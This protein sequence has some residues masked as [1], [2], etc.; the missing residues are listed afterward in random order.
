MQ[1][2]HEAIVSNEEPMNVVCLG[3]TGAAV[4]SDAHETLTRSLAQ[5]LVQPERFGD[6]LR[7]HLFALA[8]ALRPL[9]GSDVAAHGLRLLETFDAL[10]CHRNDAPRVAA[11]C[12]ELAERHRGYDLREA[13]FDLVGAALLACLR[14][15]LDDGYDEAAENA[16]AGLYG[17]IAETLIATRAFPP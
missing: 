9:F 5:L 15:L 14:E 2:G 1:L 11:L 12:T 13:H 4:G 8:P 6:T 3:S 7:A 17:E 10:I 16:W